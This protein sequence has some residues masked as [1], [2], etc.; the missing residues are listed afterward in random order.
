M[1][2]IIWEDSDEAGNMEP[3]NSDESFLT[4]EAVFPS[5]SEETHLA[6]PQE[7]VMASPDVI[8]LKEPDNSPQDPSSLPI[9]TFRPI[10]GLKFRPALKCQVKFV[11]YKEIL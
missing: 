6:L 11:K 7:P 4:K 3:L 1:N 9:F 2:G 8:S 5:S 10:T